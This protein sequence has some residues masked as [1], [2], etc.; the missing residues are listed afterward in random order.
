M[1]GGV[2]CVTGMNT[3]DDNKRATIRIDANGELVSVTTE[4]SLDDLDKHGIGCCLPV[5]ALASQPLLVYH[6]GTYLNIAQICLE[7]GRLVER[8]GVLRRIVRRYRRDLGEITQRIEAL[9]QEDAPMPE[10]PAGWSVIAID[11]DEARFKAMAGI[12]RGIRADFWHPGAALGGLAGTPAIDIIP[13]K[14]GLD[15]VSFHVC[16]HDTLVATVPAVIDET[17]A[18]GWVTNHPS[19]GCLP[20]EVHFARADVGRDATYKV[21]VTYLQHLVRAFGADQFI[22]AEPVEYGFALYKQII[23][24]ARLYATEVWDRPYVDLRQEEARLFA[25]LRKSYKSNINWCTKHLTVEYLSGADL[26]DAKINEV[27]DTIE[28]L[29]RG[30]AAKHGSGMTAELFLHPVLMARSGQGEVSIT[31]TADGEAHGITVTTDNGGMAYY[32]LGASRSIGNRNV[33]H[34]IV[35]DA[36]LRAKA[37]GMTKYVMNRLFGPS[38]AL[39]GMEAK[40][41]SERSASIAF[42]KRGFSDDCDFVHVYHVFA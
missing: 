28:S 42:F 15:H 19:S 12:E 2:N 31:H 41:A 32:A 30:M 7:S 17:H 21:I 26:T 5:K 37:R 10:L 27:Y 14:T 22:I 18:L 11:R 24:K 39:K 33:G 29:Q 6:V 35:Y 23:K 40:T 8:L 38:L 25:A 34:F 4:L 3:T 16:F 9:A 1:R 20:I 36:I 13:S